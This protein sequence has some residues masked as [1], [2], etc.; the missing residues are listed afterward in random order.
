MRSS[1]ILKATSIHLFLG[2]VSLAISTI[3]SNFCYF[4]GKPTMNSYLPTSLGFSFDIKKYAAS[5]GKTD[6]QIFH[7]PFTIMIAFVGVTVTPGMPYSISYTIGSQSIGLGNNPTPTPLLNYN[8]NTV[9]MIF[10]LISQTQS[11]SFFDT[12]QFGVTVTFKIGQDFLIA[13]YSAIVSPTI[14]QLSEPSFNSPYQ[15]SVGC[16]KWTVT[17]SLITRS[18]Y[19]SVR[20]SAPALNPIPIPGGSINMYSA[21]NIFMA[22]NYVEVINLPIFTNGSYIFKDAIDTYNSFQIGSH[23]IQF[24]NVYMPSMKN[25]LYPIELVTETGFTIASNRMC[26]ISK[27]GLNITANNVTQSSKSPSALDTFSVQL[28]APVQYNWMDSFNIKVNIPPA[29][30]KTGTLSIT[31]TSPQNPTPVIIN[32]FLVSSSVFTIPVQ[33]MQ[34]LISKGL[35]ISIVGFNNPAFSGSYEVSYQ[36]FTNANVKITEAAK[37]N[38]VVS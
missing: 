5:I 15:F 35:T 19:L 32:N 21:P 33:S 3:P 23:T 18:R 12:N 20:V 37:A 25:A 8:A 30:V 1:M 27:L 34:V 29:M 22:W 10:G 24:C 31:I 2:L 17:N 16:M 13:S 38:L 9:L 26:P 36:L 4:P 28:Q 11:L 6:L 14:F 7:S